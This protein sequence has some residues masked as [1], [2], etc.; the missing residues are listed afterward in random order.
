MLCVY[1][2]LFPN[3]NE[4]S[5]ETDPFVV[6][7]KVVQSSIKFN[8]K[9]ERL[10]LRTHSN[11]QSD[12]ESIILNGNTTVLKKPM[13]KDL[14]REEQPKFKFINS[15][16]FFAQKLEEIGQKEAGILL[17]YIFNQVKIIRIDCQ[18]VS[19]AIKLFQVLN[20]RGL[21]LSNSDLIKSFLIGKI[22]KT[23]E[24]NS[25]LRKQKED[26]FMDDWKKCEDVASHTYTSMNDFFVMYEY[27]Q[28]ASNPK[29]ALYDE[30]VNVLK[31]KDPNEIIAD[32]K[33]FI[34]SF[35]DEIYDKEDKLIYSFF[36]LKWSM[37]WRTIL[38]TALHV[39][40][41]E[42]D[43]LCK[44]LRRFY[45]LNWIAGYTLNKIKQISFNLIKWI[46][47][48]RSLSDIVADFENNL[49]SNNTISRVKEAIDGDIY[50]DPWCKPLLCLI[51]YKQTDDSTLSFISIED[52]NIHA[53]H[54][55]PRA[56]SKNE[57]WTYIKEI[58]EIDSWINTGGNLTLLSGKKNI[59]AS[60]NS[61]NK[62]ILSYDGKGLYNE[63]NSGVTSF[64]ITQKI[65][66]DYNSGKYEKIWNNVSIID[67]WNW[68]CENIE[69]ILNIDL[70]DKKLNK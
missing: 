55:I 56:Y 64:M 60:N 63:E 16:Y 35:K 54:I 22:Q 45:Y 6:D 47:E 48:G 5:L 40:Y 2:D 14:R 24:N 36:Y 32:I 66:N 37:Y 31:D 13:K 26:Q 15:A 29:K 42:Y 20:D 9:F 49:N 7:N 33:R 67:R 23:Y 50:F 38:I 11:H 44:E 68:F 61:F 58:K 65:V 27:Y 41:P 30:L 8:D 39:N 69:A 28:L 18:S 57:E 51:E 34:C 43:K 46:K 1:R 59:E 70:R 3:I 53:E 52:R 10:R 21:D 62:K 19:F 12:F 4:E 17:N 25:E